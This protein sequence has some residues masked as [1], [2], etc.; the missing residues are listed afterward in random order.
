MVHGCSRVL[1]DVSHRII[2][3]SWK[4]SSVYICTFSLST[5]KIL[6]TPLNRPWEINLTQASPSDYTMPAR[7]RKCKVSTSGVPPPPYC[8]LCGVEA[9]DS[10]DQDSMKKVIR[11]R[12]KLDME[13]GSRSND[14]LV[15]SKE[16]EAMCFPESP[17]LCSYFFRASKSVS[18]IMCFCSKDI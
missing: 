15:P 12:W 10:E 1:T 2:I 6:F 13:S 8:L 14:F 4:I 16:I 17:D 11:N 18:D 5:T 7:K 9:K 3:L